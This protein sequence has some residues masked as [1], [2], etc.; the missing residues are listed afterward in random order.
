MKWS[1][2][3]RSRKN[4]FQ[5]EATNGTSAHHAQASQFVFDAGLLSDVG[6]VRT[7]NEDSGRIICGSSSAPHNWM[8][9][10]VADGMGGHNAGE[11]ASATA[12]SVIEAAYAQMHNEPARE[13]KQALEAANST[14]HQKS[15]HDSTTQGMGTTCS[16]L[17]L[18]DGFAYSAHVGDSRIYLIRKGAI[19]LMTEDHSAVMELVKRG[20]L[21]LQEARHHP[22]KNVVTRCLGTR[23][24]VEV[25]A[26][27]E[28]RQV[29]SRFN[30]IVIGSRVVDDRDHV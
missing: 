29:K 22:D 26:W 28:P 16:A 9:A 5:G 30:L 17:L 13:L 23:P 20:E 15:I 10:V 21:T 25:S 24:Q 14:I 19:Y 11:I 2:L 6:C 7:N 1:R 18:Q 4:G 8:L 3:L 12:I 27:P